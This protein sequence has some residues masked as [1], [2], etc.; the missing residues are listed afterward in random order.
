MPTVRAQVVFKGLSGMPEDVFVNTFH[1]LTAGMGAPILDNLSGRLEA[2]YNGPGTGAAPQG[3][4]GLYMSNVINRNIGACEIKFYDL[5]T[6]QPRIP[7]V[8]TWTLFQGESAAINLPAEVAICSSFY[9]GQNI[10]RRRGRIYIGPMASQCI[11]EGP[12]ERARPSGPVRQLIAQKTRQLAVN[13]E[14]GEWAVYSKADGTAHAV[15]AGW[16]DDAFDT[17]RRRGEDATG[18]LLWT[19]A[20]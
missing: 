5:S 4:L 15:T 3:P 8:R 10:P 1:F 18:R 12:T 14:G 7:T 17:Q 2:L 19:L 6:P 20:A 16:V 13:A 11:E 9:A